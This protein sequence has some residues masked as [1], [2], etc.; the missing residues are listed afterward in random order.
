[1][2]RFKFLLIMALLVGLVFIVYA[3]ETITPEDAAQYIGQ[4]KTVCGM[5]ASAHF[6]TKT[7]GQ[8]TFHQSRQTLSK[9]GFH[10]ADL[11]IGQGQVREAA[12]SLVFRKRDL[13]NG[14]DTKLS[15]ASRDCC[16]GPIAD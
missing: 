10:S 15:G 1:M 12:R 4:Q 13:R 3:Q 8:P 16:E 11:G 7:K 9:L 6:V 5:V 14:H 2:T